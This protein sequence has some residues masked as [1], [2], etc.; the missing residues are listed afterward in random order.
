MTNP[1]HF[2]GLLYNRS[3]LLV[4]LW[5]AFNVKQQQE[6]FALHQWHDYKTL[7]QFG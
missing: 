2:M 1:L 7:L 5:N 4:Y 3:L 6:M